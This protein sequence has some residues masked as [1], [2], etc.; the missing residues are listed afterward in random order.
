MDIFEE[1]IEQR[2]IG[3]PMVL[4][5]VVETTGSTPRGAG[6]KML[7]RHDG[8]IVGTIGGGVIEKTVVD[9]SKRL[10]GTSCTKLLS[11]DLR[12]IGMICGGDMSV[13]LEALNPAPAL[14]VFGAG[15]IGKVLTQI[16]GLLGFRITVADNRPDFANKE[17]LPWVNE[18]ISSEYADTLDSLSFDD[19]TYIVILTH[20]HVHD[21]RVLEACIQKKHRY[22]GMI[23]SRKKVAD[24]LDKLRSKGIDEELIESVHSPVGIDIG[25]K[26]PAEIAVSIAAE[27]VSVR[28]QDNDET[29]GSCPSAL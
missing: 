12:D 3:N 5:T 17:N 21:Y 11:H 9:E 28:N 15:H 2:R 26:T 20:K 10:L 1:I 27:L 16:A 23:G 7:V 25:G 8:T 24:S 6:A 22:I 19:N 29:S 13:L 14:I 4:A 18:T